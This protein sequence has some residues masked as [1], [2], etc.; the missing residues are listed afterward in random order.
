MADQILSQD[1]ID[2][3]L[4]AMSKGEV[5]VGKGEGAQG[6]VA[7]P[8]DLASE[9]AVLN[10][11]F[12]GLEEICARFAILLAKALGNHVSNGI[13]V[14]FVS[15]ERIRF[16]QFVKTCSNPTSFT[17]FGME[18]LSGVALLTLDPGL[19]FS[20]IDCCFGGT[21]TALERPRQFTL[22]EQT[23]LRRL[24]LEILG[25]LQESWDALF[26]VKTAIRGTETT[27][28]FLHFVDPK[29]FVIVSVFTAKTPSFS[30]NLY[31]CL[32][33]LMLEPIREKLSPSYLSAKN[34]IRGWNPDVQENIKDT[35]VTLAVELG[36]T[37]LAVWEVLR[38]EQE[39]VILLDKGPQD[40]VL[41]KVEGVPKCFGLPGVM[42]GNRAV[43]LSELLKQEGGET[44]NGSAGN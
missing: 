21:G 12:T 20:L 39:S 25:A 19:V 35:L 13:E 10:K 36:R 43:Q 4:S 33:Y 41:V 5:E 15:S 31:L 28:D 27:P 42:K 14:A 44:Q 1:E 29:D 16:E 30:G 18:P 37:T 38:L 26:P 7:K 40:P 2:A 6:P 11:E 24:V 32:S 17:L 34:T 23:I 9:S 3:L 22:I 8:Y